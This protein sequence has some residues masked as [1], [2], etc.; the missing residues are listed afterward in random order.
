ME[1]HEVD[2]LSVKTHLHVNCVELWTDFSCDQ[3][4]MSVSNISVMHSEI[5]IQVNEPITY[6]QNLP[7][8]DGR[9][10]FKRSTAGV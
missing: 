3:D 5:K 4:E 1:R 6:S 8:D 9:S 10:S 2:G 7:M